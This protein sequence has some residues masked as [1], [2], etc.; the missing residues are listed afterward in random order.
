MYRLFMIFVFLG[1]VL[2]RI[3]DGLLFINRVE[4]NGTA[5]FHGDR[6]RNKRH[7]GLKS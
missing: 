6:V 4:E 7:M 1:N 2:L 5:N 3:F